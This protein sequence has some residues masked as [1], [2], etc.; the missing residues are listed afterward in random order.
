M[1]KATIIQNK[2]ICSNKIES[3]KHSITPQYIHTQQ[4]S[5]DKMS[6]FNLSIKHQF[7]T[8][9]SVKTIFVKFNY[10]IIL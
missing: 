6:N 10:K 9:A 8:Y 4:P 7:S 3:I 2:L 5:N 1:Q